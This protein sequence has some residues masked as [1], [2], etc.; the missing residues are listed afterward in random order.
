[1]DVRGVSE[2]G[3]SILIPPRRRT[4]F[5]P[6][7][8]RPSAPRRALHATLRVKHFA[9]FVDGREGWT[10]GSGEGVGG[11]ARVAGSGR[12][13]RGEE[14][15]ERRRGLGGKTTV[16]PLI[17]RLARGGGAR[18]GG[19][20]RAGLLAVITYF[21][22]APP[23]R[24]SRQRAAPAIPSRRHVGNLFSRPRYC[25]RRDG[26]RTGNPLRVLSTTGV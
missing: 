2:G 9:G 23:R 25:R 1:M 18:R 17:E 4:P 21:Y 20:E 14:R 13:A 22:Y 12:A 16:F 19:V 5:P 10:V 26:L 6:G 24:V 11:N 7:E 8:K 15:Y 3:A